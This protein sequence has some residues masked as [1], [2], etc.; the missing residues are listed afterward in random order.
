MT[1]CG[2][3]PNTTDGS[4]LTPSLKHA[5]HT[6]RTAPT[7]PTSSRD[8]SSSVQT[9]RPECDICRA[10]G[11]QR[12]AKPQVNGVHH[13]SCN[14]YRA[15]DAMPI[16]WPLRW[17]RS[18]PPGG[19]ERV[20]HHGFSG[21]CFVLVGDGIRRLERRDSDGLRPCPAATQP[22]E[23]NCVKQNSVS[24]W[25]AAAVLHVS[26]SL[27]PWFRESWTRGVRRPPCSRRA[28][29]RHYTPWGYSGGEMDD[30]TPD[31]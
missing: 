15:R 16:G 8:H 5:R 26:G 21:G 27:A 28:R 12:F 30:M 20:V 6:S 4:A 14:P 7:P 25:T 29:P 9:A 23:A 10:V 18:A 17:P 3:H 13:F 1:S 24:S 19:V 31:S 2:T 22:A 11:S